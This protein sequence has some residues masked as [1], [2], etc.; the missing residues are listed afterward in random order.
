MRIEESLPFPEC[1]NCNRYVMKV[2]EQT[3]LMPSFTERIVKVT[4]KHQKEC[5]Q[6]RKELKEMERKK[7]EK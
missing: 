4:C 3:Y 7:H 6:Q 5:I 1:V 2:H